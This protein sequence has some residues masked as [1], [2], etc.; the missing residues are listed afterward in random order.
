MIISGTIRNTLRII[1]IGTFMTYLLLL[2]GCMTQQAR[3]SRVNR[4]QDNIDERT[5]GRQERWK[6]RGE[7]EDARSNAF[8]EA[9]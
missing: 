8:F 9:M 5:R 7:R 4:R 2:S 1:L 3:T 6:E